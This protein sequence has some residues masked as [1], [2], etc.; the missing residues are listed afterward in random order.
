MSERAITLP[1]SLR[2]R[3]AGRD[4]IDIRSPMRGFTVRNRD[5]MIRE[6]RSTNKLEARSADDGVPR[7]VGYASTYDDPY[8]IGVPIDEG[9]WGWTEIIAKGAASKSVRE[10]DDV[11]LFFNHDGFDLAS[12]KNGTLTLTSDSIGLRSDAE[13]DAALTAFARRDRR[14]GAIDTRR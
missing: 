8:D 12:T 5:G 1:Q 14:F 7:I 10:R 3:L 13:I 2:Q 6:A 9:G 4:D 11:Y